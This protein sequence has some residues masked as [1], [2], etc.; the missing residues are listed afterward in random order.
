MLMYLAA[1]FG[2]CNEDYQLKEI[3]PVQTTH[4]VPPTDPKTG[5]DMPKTNQFDSPIDTGVGITVG[6]PFHEMLPGAI[7][8]VQNA[9]QADIVAY[10]IH[11]TEIVGGVDKIKEAWFNM[12]RRINYEDPSV[13]AK[14]E[15]VAGQ[16]AEYKN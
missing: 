10:M 13:D 2:C 7:D 16:N 14:L 4:S 6:R 12:R 3:F 11:E 8:Q 9:R 15:F 5:H 1:L